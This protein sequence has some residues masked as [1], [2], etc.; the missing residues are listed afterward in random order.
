MNSEALIVIAKVTGLAGL[1]IYLALTVFSKVV[2]AT[3]SK[4]LASQQVYK[5]FRTIVLTTGAIAVIGIVT[6]AVLNYRRIP[7]SSNIPA[8]DARSLVVAGMVVD[9][10]NNMGVGQAEITIIGQALSAVSED[11]GNFRI[12]LPPGES[13]PVRISVTK[14][15]YYKADESVTPPTHDL[16]IQLQPKSK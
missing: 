2:E 3:N 10:S 1:S 15:G 6:W 5:L 14:Q 8:N 12:A 11:S 4:I 7:S 13:G 16:I 9:R